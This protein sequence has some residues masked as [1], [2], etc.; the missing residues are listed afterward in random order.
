[1]RQSLFYIF[2]LLSQAIFAQYKIDST[3]K[4]NFLRIFEKLPKE[5]VE[6]F[7]PASQNGLALLI[8][9]KIDTINKEDLSTDE[10]ITIHDI[11]HESGEVD[12]AISWPSNKEIINE[13]FP[14]PLS[15]SCAFMDDTLEI[16]SSIYL[17][18]GFSVTIKLHQSKAK[19][20]YTEVESEGKVFRRTLKEE[21]VSSLTIPALINLLTL[22]RPIRN[23][24]TE[25]YGKIAITTSPY[26]SYINA[27]GFKHDY[28][29]KRVKIDFYFRCT[30]IK[31]RTTRGLA[32]W[33]LYE[34]ILIDIALLSYISI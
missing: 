34:H 22:D 27:W 33:R 11:N 20:F 21:K 18:S 17:F 2:F 16:T 7:G 24:V 1:M 14:Y 25:F 19:S 3:V 12:S 10:L 26:Y 32:L 6:E 8:R 4:T 9:D 23:D 13:N 28:I 30:G 5:S 15:C 31:Q 29:Y